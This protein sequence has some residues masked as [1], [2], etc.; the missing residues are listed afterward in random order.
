MSPARLPI[1]PHPP[2]RIDK[3]FGARRHDRIS[4]GRGLGLPVIAEGI[5]TTDQLRALLQFGCACGQG[6]LY[7][8]PMS[9]RE[10]LG[11]IAKPER[12]LLLDALGMRKAA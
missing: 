8:Q 4:I 2:A 6:Y 5:E 1:P 11:V 9:A 3:R 12:H 7:G 10:A